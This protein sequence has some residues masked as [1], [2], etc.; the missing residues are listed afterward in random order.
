MITPRALEALCDR[1]PIAGRELAGFD[2]SSTRHERMVRRAAKPSPHLRPQLDDLTWRLTAG[3]G[4]DRSESGHARCGIPGENLEGQWR[5]AVELVVQQLQ[6]RQGRTPGK[7][8]D[9]GFL[10][11]ETRAAV[12]DPGTQ[13]MRAEP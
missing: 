2:D 3:H 8:N 10:A 5:T 7:P 13:E 4:G 11:G 12:S 6:R 9:D 1:Q